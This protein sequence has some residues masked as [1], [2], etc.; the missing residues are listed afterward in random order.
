MRHI[1]EA[2]TFSFS[3]NRCLDDGTLEHD[4]HWYCK[5]HHPPTVAAYNKERNERWE[6]KLAEQ[7]NMRSAA[8]REKTLKYRALEWLRRENPALVKEWEDQL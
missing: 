5:Q 7:D 1:C 4:G 6:R 3:I 8:K 2:I